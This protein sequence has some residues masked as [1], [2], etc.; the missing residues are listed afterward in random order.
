SSEGEVP[1]LLQHLHIKHCVKDR[2]VPLVH[3]RLGCQ[4]SHFLAPLGLHRLDE[5]SPLPQSVEQG[6]PISLL[7]YVDPAGLWPLG[8]H[9]QY[10]ADSLSERQPL[11]YPV[12]EDP[13]LADDCIDMPSHIVTTG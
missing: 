11:V 10:L 8:T 9:L 6:S 13:L 1:K 5:S 2:D 12:Y 4:G 3:S 7:L